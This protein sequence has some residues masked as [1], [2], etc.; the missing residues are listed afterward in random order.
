MVCGNVLMIVVA[1]VLTADIQLPYQADGVKVGEV[2]S[3]S[4]IV[5]VRLTAEAARRMEGVI[6]AKEYPQWMPADSD[7]N[8]YEGACPGVAGRVRLRYAASGASGELRETDWVRVGPETDFTHQFHLKDLAPD[9]TYEFHAQTTGVEEGGGICTL[10]GSFTTAP[11][12]QQRRPI[13][14]TIMTCQ[15][16]CDLDHPD[17]FHIYDSMLKLK[18]LFVVPTGDN[19]Y[20]DNDPP[21][22]TYVSGARFHWHR[23][24]GM[25]RLIRFHLAVPGYWEKDDHDTYCD[26]AWPGLVREKMGTLSFAEGLRI[27]REQ[28]PMGETTWRTF[29]WGQGLQIWLTEGRDFRSP[30]DMKDGPGKSI[31]GAQQK[32]W[33]KDTLLASDAD[34]RILVSPTP[35]VGPDRPNKADNHC[36]KAFS[37][38]GDEF[39]RWAAANLRGNFFIACGDRHW[40]YHSVHPETGLHEFGC[41]PAS[42]PHA[43]GTPGEDPAYHRFHRVKG[44]FLSITVTPTDDGKQST[45]VLRHHDVFGNVVHEYQ[46]QP[47]TKK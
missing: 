19:V 24:Y 32:R 47:Q 42:D 40:Q 44:G 30:N 20:Y 1:H 5:W 35:I 2:T 27:F 14:C 37:H 46:P 9:T 6:P 7:V 43:A 29:R 17:G 28:V 34:W 25:P 8:R 23:M 31:W 33:L 13:T 21:N 12:P 38:E 41:G 45:I 11:K 15:A 26:D 3:D 16:Y 36:N 10:S 4:A 22:A 18:P 39:R